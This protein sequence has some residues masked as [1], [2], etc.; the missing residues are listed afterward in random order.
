MRSFSTVDGDVVI[1]KTIEMVEG[2]ELLRQK[3]ERVVGT[4]KGE[5]EFDL[6]EGINFRV[7]LTK[8]PDETEIRATIDEALTRIDETFVI[9]AFDLK[10]ER[11]RKATISYKA[12]NSDGVE[13]GG[14]YNLD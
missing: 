3:V 4:N 5:W 11:G 12:V 2:K 9:T 10:M 14:D 13:V 1:G 6:D 7:I 8:N